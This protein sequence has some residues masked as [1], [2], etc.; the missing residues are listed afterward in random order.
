MV[1]IQSHSVSDGDTDRFGLW[2]DGSLKAGDYLITI[3]AP[4]YVPIEAQVELVE[5]RPSLLGFQSRVTLMPKA[6]Q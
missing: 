5:A 4:G 6:A 2:T 1:G 3:D